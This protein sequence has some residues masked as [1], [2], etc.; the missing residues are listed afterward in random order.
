MEALR[1]LK[2]LQSALISSG[3]DLYTD[4]RKPLTIHGAIPVDVTVRGGIGNTTRELLH[5]VSELSALFIS[6]SCLQE[7]HIISD[8]FPLPVKND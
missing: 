6:K 8:N 3:I 2:I 4:D 5:I 1:K 7:L